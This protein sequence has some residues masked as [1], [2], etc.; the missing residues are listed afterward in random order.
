M[1]LRRERTTKYGPQKATG[2]KKFVMEEPIPAPRKYR[3][4]KQI[5]AAKRHEEMI[6]ET[7]KA[8]KDR[9]IEN[10]F[11]FSLKALKMDTNKEVMK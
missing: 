6:K 5:E 9:L 1:E 3:T 7:L 8:K 10:K 2:D 11:V 4:R